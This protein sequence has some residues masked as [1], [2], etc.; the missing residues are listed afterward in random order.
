[1]KKEAV[2]VGIGIFFAI[3]IASGFEIKL[4]RDPFMDLLK[5]R[6]IRQ[7]ELMKKAKIAMTK[8][9]RFNKEIDMITSSLT[10][11]MIITSKDT[12]LNAA[13]I[14]G[15]SGVP[16]VVTKGYKLQDNVYIKEIKNNEV[17]V[18]VDVNGVVKTVS[19]K[20]KK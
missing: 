10:V 6:Q 12:N 19:L 1:M 7:A 8:Q 5:L 4:K 15:P 16:V 18:A 13:L 17:V 20:L 3:S 2:L 11:K 14:V 9:E